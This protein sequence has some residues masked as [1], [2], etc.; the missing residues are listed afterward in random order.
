MRGQ[1]TAWH[2]AAS[3]PLSLP[4]PLPCAPPW[5]GLGPRFAERVPWGLFELS[6]L[7][8]RLCRWLSSQLGGE[9]GEGIGEGS[10]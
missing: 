4:V 10:D 1:C 9:T 6:R 3:A 5:A 7:P 2:P 8:G